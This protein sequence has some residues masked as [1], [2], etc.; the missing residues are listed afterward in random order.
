MSE[1]DLKLNLMKALASEKGTSFDRA[2][3][4]PVN[5][6]NLLFN[7]STLFLSALLVIPS[8]IFSC[9]YAPIYYVNSVFSYVHYRRRMESYAK[10]TCSGW[11]I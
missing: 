7:L 5:W 6:Q 3:F 1:V 9:Y 8:S 11:F 10:A 2:W 4:A